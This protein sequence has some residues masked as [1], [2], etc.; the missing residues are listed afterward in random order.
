MTKLDLT[1][2]WTW[3]AAATAGLLLGA[4]GWLLL[5]QLET[6]G[7]RRPRLWAVRGRVSK[8]AGAGRVRVRHLGGGI[9]ELVGRIDDPELVSALV[10]E[11]SR[12]EGVQVVLNRLWSVDRAVPDRSES[13]D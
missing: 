2:R 11:A 12:V 10:E 9:V 6:D 3:W 8:L 4:G 1:G 13:G 5:R 7:R